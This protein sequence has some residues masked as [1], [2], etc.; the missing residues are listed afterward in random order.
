[1]NRSGYT[2]LSSEEGIRQLLK[3]WLV[4]LLFVVLLTGLIGGFVMFGRISWL[5]ILI[6]FVPVL[7]TVFLTYGTVL[8]TFE[9]YKFGEVSFWQ[10]GEVQVGRTLRGIVDMPAKVAEARF[11]HAELICVEVYWRRPSGG[12][13]VAADIVERDRWRT[14][15]QFPIMG[16]AKRLEVAIAL[17]IPADKN[18]TDVPEYPTYSVLDPAEPPPGAEYGRAYYRWELRVSAATPG[19]DLERTFRVRVLPADT[20]IPMQLSAGQPQVPV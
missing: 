17:D 18:P 1:M 11:L 19:T 10:Q 14:T 3:D 6:V 5:F 12:K 20:G 15:R 8:K 16:N 2:R 4:T 9:Y 7:F 13:V